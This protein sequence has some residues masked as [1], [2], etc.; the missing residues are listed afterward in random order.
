MQHRRDSEQWL[1]VKGRLM[2]S[3]TAKSP[4]V[5]GQDDGSEVGEG[6]GMSCGPTRTFPHLDPVTGSG[7]EV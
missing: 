7:R 2:G 1:W 5:Q 4:G 6:A 3:R